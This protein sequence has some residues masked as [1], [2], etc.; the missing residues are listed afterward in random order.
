MI[1]SI[2][3]KEE[4]EKEIQSA[5]TPN[6]DL[7]QR[8][9]KIV[10]SLQKLFLKLQN[11]QSTGTQDLR[12]VLFFFKLLLKNSFVKSIRKA[13]GWTRENAFVQHD[14]QEFHRKLCDHIDIETKVL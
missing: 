1:F 7:K 5:N 4:L 10:L 2:D 8:G 12:F 6:N 9:K 11:N 14:V 3:T 13:F